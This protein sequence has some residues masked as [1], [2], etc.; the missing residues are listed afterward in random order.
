MRWQ[1]DEEVS[2]RVT[3]LADCLS[4]S[5]GHTPVRLCLVLAVW[6]S[7]RYERVGHGGLQDLESCCRDVPSLAA[8][9]IPPAVTTAEDVAQGEAH[10]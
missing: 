8:L 2:S 6:P 5:L 9:G 10:I 1:I 4:H 7:L 3:K